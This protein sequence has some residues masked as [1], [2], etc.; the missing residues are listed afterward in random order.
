MLQQTQVATVIPYYERFLRTFPTIKH[1]ARAPLERVLESWSGLGYYR[2]ARHLHEAAQVLVDRSGGR[3]PRTYSEL[4]ALPGIGDYTARALLSIAFA[5]PYAV[6]DGNVARVLARLLARRGN[7][8]QA[9]FRRALEHFLNTFLSRRAPGDFNQALM[10][11]G[12]LICLPRGPRCPV[13]P[14]RRICRAARLGKPEAYPE[15][16]PRRAVE[17]RYLAAALISSGS[18]VA[19]VQGLEDGLLSDLWN[20]PAALAHSR[21]QALQRLKGKLKLLGQIALATEKPLAEL[22]HGITFRNIHINVYR[23]EPSGMR[24]GNVLRWF[25]LSRLVRAPSQSGRVAIS[26]LAHKIATAIAQLD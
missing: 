18:R 8:H 3:F 1:L 16:R 25:P 23:A 13:C 26:K 2:R 17:D 20:F 11:L 19:L 6:L 22:R 21:S 7:L 10:E 14:L 4:R 9:P 15:P 12:Q 24:F 5:Q